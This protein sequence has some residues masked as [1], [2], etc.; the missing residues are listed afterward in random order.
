MPRKSKHDRK[1]RYAGLKNGV[2]KHFTFPMY[3]GRDR[4]KPEEL[5]AYLQT[6]IDAIQAADD[7][8]NVWQTRLRERRS[9]EKEAASTIEAAK[10]LALAMFDGSPKILADF[11]LKQPKKKGPRT[12]EA[13]VAM[14]TKARSTRKERGTMGKRQRAKLKRGG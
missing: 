10:N 3:M 8:Y 5:V 7:A 2:A 6:L 12:T 11:D 13:K 1:R 4:W 9:L 14:V